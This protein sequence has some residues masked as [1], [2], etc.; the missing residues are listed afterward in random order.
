VNL[1]VV[2]PDT[3]SERRFDLSI[4]IGR[5]KAKLESVTGI[6]A[7]TQ[8]LSLYRSEDDRE[9]ILDV[10]D[11]SQQLGYYQVGDL[12]V[13]KVE[14]SNPSNSLVGHLSDVSQVEKFELSD[15]AYAQRQ[16]TVLVFKQ[17]N[18]L[19]RFAKDGEGQ[20]SQAA[21]PMEV[22]LKIGSRCEVDSGDGTFSKRGTVRFVG[23]TKFGKG[24]NV[25]V[26]VE[27]DEPLGKNDGS[28]DGVR[29]FTCR[30]MHGAFVRPD[31]VKVGD[32]AVK[33]I[34]EEL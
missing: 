21:A 20:Q 17:R 3:R 28:V 25:W 5:L 23:E 7:S 11:D 12:Q 1:I 8:K 9:P 19:G 16:D 4:S 33:D 30:S 29:Y 34:E 31:R 6:A 22:D 13:L 14:D 2:S 26:G 10:S 18:K 32:F 15:Q 27:Y 24:A